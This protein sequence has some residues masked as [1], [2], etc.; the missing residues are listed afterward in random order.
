L[1]DRH[2]PNNDPFAGYNGPIV[3]GDV[4]IVG[5]NGVGS[6]GDSGFKAWASPE[7][8]RVYDVRSGKQL[9]QFH[10]NKDDDS[11]GK[12]SGE[13]VGNMGAWAPLSADEQLGIV[14]VPTSAPTVSY[15]GGHRPGNN[16]YSDCLLAIDAKTG[17]LIW[18]FQM[19]HHDMWDYDN[20]SP[21]TLGDIT[22][23]G[24]RIHAVMQPNKNGFLYVFDRKTGKPVWPI[25]ERP[26]PKA[27][28]PGEEVSP[29]QPIPTKPP[30]FDRQGITED[31][32]IDFTPALHGEALKFMQAYVTGPEFT[33]PSLVD[34]PDTGKKGTLMLPGVWGSGNWNTG[35]F[36]PETGIFYAV[37]MTSA[38]NF[39]LRAGKTPEETGEGKVR[40][41]LD[42]KFG[43]QPAYG[44]G[45]E[46]LPL[47]KPPYGRVTALDLTKG[48]KLWTIANG[49][50]PRNDPA[51]KSLNLPPLGTIGRP[52]PLVTKTL[53]F[54]GESSDS[55]AGH[56]GI[57]GPAHLFAYDKATGQRLWEGAL[58]V[59]TTGGPMTY[60][61][62]GKQYIVVP[63][64][65]KDYGTAWVAFALKH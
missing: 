65:G 6:V 24:R 14:Y 63:I 33:P 46:G 13:H 59:G 21:P 28:L 11:W 50:G 27:I 3:V 60:E 8:I 22:V 55:T 38:W 23:E 43:Q 39:G 49:D 47:V 29:T 52:A 25:E 9:W 35:S 48:T 31:D 34:D 26:A 42:I 16:L 36:D 53:L 1:L 45:P 10:V 62:H 37:S 32:L 4:I 30:A 56:Y 18:Y 2:T 20:A 41:G 61:V 19:V 17:K 12:S 57:A 40:Y 58:P 44:P 5:G 7:D 64:G 54:V 51:L 15:Y